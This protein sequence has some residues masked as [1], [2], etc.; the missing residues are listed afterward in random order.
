MSFHDAPDAIE[1]CAPFAFNG[2]GIF[3][4]RFQE[5][6]QAR[7]R[8]NSDA[9]DRQ[10]IPPVS[11]KSLQGNSLVIVKVIGA[12]PIR[13]WIL[14]RLAVSQESIMG[15]PVIIN[16]SRFGEQGAG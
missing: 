6:V 8:K 7:Y 1:I 15:V 10:S 12:Q 3:F 2:G 5:I 9:G 13:R 11:E 14:S 4:L 16:R